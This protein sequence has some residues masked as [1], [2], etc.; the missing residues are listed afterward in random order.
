M[1]QANL[2]T[3]LHNEIESQVEAF[4]AMGKTIEQVPINCY[5]REQV[6]LRDKAT[7]LAVN[8][9]SIKAPRLKSGEVMREI[10]RQAW[11]QRQIKEGRL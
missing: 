10:E 1:R 5:Q 4:L 7:I 11:T 9:T 8:R 2:K 6:T 3:Q